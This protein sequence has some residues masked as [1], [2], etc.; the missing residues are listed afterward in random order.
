MIDELTKKVQEEVPWCMLFA[1]DI[2]LI[3]ESRSRLNETLEAWRATLESKGFKMSRNK[4]EYLECNFSGK[5]PEQEIAVRIRNEVIT[6]SNVLKYLG[7][8]IQADG[9]VD[10][11][12][13]HRI[14][15]G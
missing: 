8:M 6:K 3:D 7:S 15:V 11:D 1:D 4:T 5:E 9:E 10:E 13:N 2:V 12:V 14:R